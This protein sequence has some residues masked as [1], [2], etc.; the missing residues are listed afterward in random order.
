MRPAQG[1]FGTRLRSPE[2]FGKP[3]RGLGRV[4]TGGGVS[5]ILTLETDSARKFNNG[6]R[7]I[8]SP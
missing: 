2:G 4:G 1:I 6:N 8:I 3:S 7:T 5:R